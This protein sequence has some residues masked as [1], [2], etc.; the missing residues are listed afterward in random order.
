VQIGYESGWGSVASFLGS[1]SDLIECG[2]VGEVPGD[3]FGVEQN[4][5]GPVRHFEEFVGHIGGGS[6]P[7]AEG[8]DLNLHEVAVRIGVVVRERRPMVH[9]GG[10]RYA[11]VTQTQI[12][13]V[14]VGEVLEFER[15]V[16]KPV[17]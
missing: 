1:H 3:E 10:G 4:P 2:A 15:G 13:C 5:Q 14:E 11:E 16:V 7:I 17:V 6:S 8:V 12:R 9:A